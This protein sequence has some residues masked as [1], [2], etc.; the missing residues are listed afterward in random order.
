MVIYLCADDVRDVIDAIKAQFSSAH[1]ELSTKVNL[2][3]KAMGNTTITPS[4]ASRVKLPEPR[5]YE[6]Q[7][8]AK[9]VDNFLFDMEQYFKMVPSISEDSKVVMATMYLI[10]D[11]KLWWRTKVDDMDHQHCKIETWSDLK[12]EIK[13]QFYPENASLL[14]RQRL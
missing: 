6:G 14:A 11:A 7:R 8:D 1:E 9:E 12:R 13:S 3:V 4:E 10:G 5:P 2:L